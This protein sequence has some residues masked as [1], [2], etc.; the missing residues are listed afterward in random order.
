[1]KLRNALASSNGGSTL[2]GHDRRSER[3][4]IAA[5]VAILLPVILAAIGL[6]VDNGMLYAEKRQMQTAADATAL[7]AAHE[8]RRQNYFGY[9]DIARADAARN[10]FE[11]GG[12]VE[13]DINVPPQSGPRAGDGNFVEVII[14]EQVPLYFMRVFREEPAQVESRAVAGLVAADACIFVL[15]PNASGA[16]TVA[17][18]AH[19]VLQGCGIHV[20]SSSNTAARTIGGGSVEAS[21][22]GVVGNYSGNGFFPTPQTGVYEQTDP[23]AEL[24]EPPIGACTF[25]EQVTIMDTQVLNPGTYCGGIKVTATGHATL[26]PGIYILKGGGLT[27]QAAGQIEGDE[28]MFFN[29]F[30]PGYPYDPIVFSAASYSDLS[31]PISGDFKGILFYQDRDVVS[32]A[33]N[34]FAGTPNTDFSG[35]CYF[36]TTDVR[37]VGTSATNSQHTMIVARRLEFRGTADFSS[38][39]PN[40]PLLPTALAIARVVE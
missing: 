11:E 24:P 25:T 17:G 29:T 40:S 34:I 28:V 15:D 27:L 4:A 9:Q 32:N 35:V 39:P 30:G 23:L 1:M 22:V 5:L 26:N 20:N 31:A 21:A 37:Y 10:G 8:W 6:A 19:V 16:L 7:T 18:D 3:G 38:M 36:P 12:D 14:R 33:L 13:I 2:H